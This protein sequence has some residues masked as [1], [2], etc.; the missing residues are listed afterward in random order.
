MKEVG[1]FTETQGRQTEQLL[2]REMVPCDL[3]GINQSQASYDILKE[4][5][6]EDELEEEDRW[7]D[8]ETDQNNK[9]YATSGT[10]DLDCYIEIEL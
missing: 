6:D 7:F 9:I 1:F 2:G 4:Y 5:I 3:T 8:I 10:V